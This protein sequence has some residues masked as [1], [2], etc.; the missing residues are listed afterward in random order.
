M[1]CQIDPTPVIMEASKIS[2]EGGASAYGWLVVV[3]SLLLAAA[4]Y[5]NFIQYKRNNKIQDGQMSLIEKSIETSLKQMQAVEKLDGKVE[6]LDKNI[7]VLT[8]LIN[9]FIS[10]GNA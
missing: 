2:P 9:T 7:T 8:A 4:I 10:K 6:D 5:A 3:I 1:F